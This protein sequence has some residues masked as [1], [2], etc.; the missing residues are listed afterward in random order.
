[1][2]LAVSQEYK[3]YLEESS[4]GETGGGNT[5][6]SSPDY[7]SLRHTKDKNFIYVEN[8]QQNKSPD[9]F[10]IPNKISLRLN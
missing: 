8:G 9:S 7:S 1:M 3:A 10:T 5:F 2:G 6:K 4:W